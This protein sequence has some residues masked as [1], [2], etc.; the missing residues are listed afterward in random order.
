MIEFKYRKLKEIVVKFL[1]DKSLLRPV[2]DSFQYINHISR[3]FLLW[4][5]QINVIS[6]KH[7]K[8]HFQLKVVELFATMQCCNA[9]FFQNFFCNAM[10]NVKFFFQCNVAM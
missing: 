9:M 10:C 2:I 5:L 6:Q 1:K 7:L 8:P 4:F 3:F